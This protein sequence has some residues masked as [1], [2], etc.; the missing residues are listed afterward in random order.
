MESKTGETF[1][2][3]RRDSEFL[4]LLGK[5]ELQLLACVHAR[6]RRGMTRKTSCRKLVY[7][8]GAILVNFDVGVTFLPG[9]APSPAMWFAPM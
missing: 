3:E 5:Y 8:C 4:A 7:G 6:F 1:D 9:P 2:S